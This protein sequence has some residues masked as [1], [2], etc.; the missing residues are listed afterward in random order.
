MKWDLRRSSVNPSFFMSEVVIRIAD[1]ND[2]EVLTE[3]GYKTFWDTFHSHPDNDPKDF[4]EY[5]KNAFNLQK[6]GGEISDKNAIF[7]LAEIDQKAVGYAK[8]QFFSVEDPI[9]AKQPVEIVRIYAAK[10]FIGKGIGKKLMDTSIKISVEL[11]C[12]VIW[13][14]V[15]EHNPRAI[16]F[17]E[18]NG[19]HEVGSH[20]FQMGSDKQTDL[21][22]QKKL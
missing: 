12:D 2:A 3:L 18:K 22:M 14:G 20:S 9:E 6:I 15:W 13:L 1:S 21:L 17:Y 4:A 11:G 16:R 8:L 10:D 5:L 19:F 7:L